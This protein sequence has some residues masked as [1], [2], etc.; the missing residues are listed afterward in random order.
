MKT[1]YRIEKM[2]DAT[3][4]RMTAVEMPEKCEFLIGEGLAWNLIAC[5]TY[6]KISDY[7]HHV[8][9]DSGVIRC[10]REAVTA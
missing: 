1:H 4:C 8:T 5:T 2:P 6:A 3:A 9:D 7:T 10:F